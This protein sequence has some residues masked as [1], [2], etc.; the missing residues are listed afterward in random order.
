MKVKELK[1]SKI[2]NG[3]RRFVEEI[4]NKTEEFLERDR[5]T[6]LYVFDGIERGEYEGLGIFEDERLIGFIFFS[7]N[8]LAD[9]VIE[10]LWIAVDP[11]FYGKGVAQILWEEFFREVKV[12]NARLIVLETQARHKRARSF[13]RKMG[14]ER[15]A[16]IKDFYAEG[17]SKEIWVKRI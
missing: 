16:E 14:F 12:R 15:E 5:K 10:L 9:S 7:E 3:H 2:F 4:V 8:L 13:Y 6:C 17:E 11:E 1:I